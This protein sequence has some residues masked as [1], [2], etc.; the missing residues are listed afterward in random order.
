M[1]AWK[2]QCQAAEKQEAE[3]EARW[4]E[5]KARLNNKQVMADRMSRGPNSDYAC[6]ETD[7]FGKAVDE[8]AELE[9]GKM[10]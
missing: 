1:L 7:A 9:K 10:P 4:N 5:L 6:G 3:L 2:T 8:M